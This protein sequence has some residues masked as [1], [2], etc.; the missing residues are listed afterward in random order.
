MY[1]WHRRYFS[2]GQFFTK[3]VTAIFSV[4]AQFSVNKNSVSRKIKINFLLIIES[5]YCQ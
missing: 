2:V 3:A 5:I 1:K 4:D